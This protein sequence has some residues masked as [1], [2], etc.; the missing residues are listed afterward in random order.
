MRIYDVLVVGRG[1]IG[2][3]AA[4]HLAKNGANVALIGP[5]E[6]A[7]HSTHTGVFGSHYDSGRI[8]RILDPIPYYAKIAKRSIH[9]YD[10]TSQSV[11]VPVF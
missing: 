5:G 6:P 7:D 1:L 4:R 2:S 9:R 10:H 11:P 8:V 3:A